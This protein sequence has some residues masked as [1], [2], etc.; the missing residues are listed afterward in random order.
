MHQ[1][2]RGTWLGMD[3]GQ[4]PGSGGAGLLPQVIRDVRQDHP[5]RRLQAV[6]LPYQVDDA[7]R[8]LRGRGQAAGVGF[9]KV[10]DRPAPLQGAAAMPVLV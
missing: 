10:T 1:T 3:K 5:H 7:F 4:L 8:N 6:L 9:C 2:L